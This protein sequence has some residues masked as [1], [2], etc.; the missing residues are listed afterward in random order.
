M[1]VSEPCQRLRV[2]EGMAERGNRPRSRRAQ[3]DAV[4]GEVGFEPA[5]DEPQANRGVPE[6]H[7]NRHD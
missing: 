3:R 1:T 7:P 4:S 5:R 2:S 6:D